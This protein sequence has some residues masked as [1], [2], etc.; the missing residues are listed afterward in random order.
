MKPI[1]PRE[2]LW[3]EKKTMDEFFELDR[4]NEDFFEVFVTLREEPFAV[5]ANEVKVFNEVYYQLTRMV[6]E[7][8]LPSDLDKYVADIKANMGWNYSAE[9]VM[10]MAYFLLSL[11]DK[12][13]RPLNKFFTKAINERFF[14]CL[15]WKPFKHRFEHIKKENRNI[16]YHFQP[17]PI[18]VWYFQDK[19]VDWKTITCGYDLGCLD[20]VINLWYKIE[21]KKEVAWMINETSSFSTLSE[22]ENNRILRFLNIYMLSDGSDSVGMC[23]ECSPYDDCQSLKVRINEMNS[24]KAVLQSRIKDLEA[25]NEKLKTLQEK[26]KNNGKARRF[27]LV[28]IVDY[29][30]GRVDWNDA[31]DI[32]AMLN[33][34]LRRI[35]TKEDS[36]LVDSIETEFINRRYGNTYIREQTV[37]P[38]VGNY[39]PKIRTQNVEVPVP[40]IEEQ[41]EQELLEDE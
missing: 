7:H 23:A 40:Q 3:T 11:I 2:M 13:V 12:K 37:I 10:S 16:I 18:D 15:Y 38:S 17:C 36:D 9:L 24:E 4:V 28:E 26:K 5:T 33:K 34:L 41:D 35:G 27:T 32:V 19:Y 21:D 25:E 30:K 6:F 20:D 14:G 1:L 22:T 8:P 39:K 31:K 29:C